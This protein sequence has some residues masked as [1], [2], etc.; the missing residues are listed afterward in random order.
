MDSLTGQVSAIVAKHDKLERKCA[1]QQAELED[2]H[3]KNQDY[4]NEKKVSDDVRVQLEAKLDEKDCEILRLSVL[5]DNWKT[6]CQVFRDELVKVRAEYELVSDKHVAV[7]EQYRNGDAKLAR[8]ELQIKNM[9]TIMRRKIATNRVVLVALKAA[10]KVLPTLKEKRRYARIFELA[11][12]APYK[13]GVSRELA[14]VL[15]EAGFNLSWVEPGAA[16][17]TPEQMS[18]EPTTAAAE[19]DTDMQTSSS[20]GVVN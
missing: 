2:L 12:Q 13:D 20:Q 11:K 9:I 8:R 7:K 16:T 17:Q 14:G 4:F 19:Q 6:D 15:R 10:A 1:E 18:E 5:V 3:A